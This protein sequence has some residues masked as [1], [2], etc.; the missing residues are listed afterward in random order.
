MSVPLQHLYDMRLYIKLH[1]YFC[2]NSLNPQHCHGKI[3]TYHSH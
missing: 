1:E 2:V 3:R